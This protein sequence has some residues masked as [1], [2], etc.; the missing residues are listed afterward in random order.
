MIKVTDVTKYFDDFKVL[1]DISMHVR[2]GTIYGLIGPNGAG[3]TTIINHINGV[4]TPKC[5]EIKINGEPVFE[6]E[7]VKQSVLNI[8]DDWFYYSTFTIKEM[9]RFYRDM[10]PAFSNERYEAIKGIFKLD[11][12]RQIRKLSKGMKKQVA[13][14]LSLSAMP[15]VLILD[16]PLDGL[17]PVMRKQVLNLVIADVADREMTVLVSSHNLRE[18]ED[19]CDWVGIIHQGRMILEKPLDD[20]KGSVHKY[21]LVI[22]AE[23][24][25]EL[26]KTGNVLHISHTGSVRSVIIRGDADECDKKMQELAPSLCERISLTLEEVFIYELG[27][28]GYD[29]TNILV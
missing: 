18:L 11:E 5:G 24:D 13:F 28:L 16:E 1:D 6:N 29:F 26:E 12:K 23:K 3:K 17:D 21:Q 27:G 7:K 9:A 4:L 8:S 14:W 22:P 25:D 15:D 20:L 19:I 10:Y 2:R